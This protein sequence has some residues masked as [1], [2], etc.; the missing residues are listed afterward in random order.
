MTVS[1]FVIAFVILGSY[2]RLANGLLMVW[3][4]RGKNFHHEVE[5][6]LRRGNLK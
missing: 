6:F 4:R 3:E 2:L 1:A 5:V